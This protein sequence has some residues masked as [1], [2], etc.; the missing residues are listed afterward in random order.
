MA[1]WFRNAALS[2][3]VLAAFASIASAT[4]ITL[5]TPIGATTSGGAVDA[6]AEFITGAG[7]LTI[8]LD[9]LFADPKSIAQL[10][11]GIDFTL[12]DL[13]TTGSLTSSSGQQ[14][15]VASNGSY[16]TGATTSTGWGVDN[17][18]LGGIELTALGFSSPAQLIIGA[19]GAGNTYNNANSS[20]T[21]G[22]HDP[23]L[24]QTATFT[25]AIAGL[26]ASDKVT[27][28]TFLFGTT[29]GVD[30]VSAPEPSSLEMLGMGLI[31][32][33]GLGAFRRSSA[34]QASA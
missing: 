26:T 5:T 25:L 4:D 16:T 15:T 19:P 23:F 11:S 7:T 33:V 21:N 17:N 24:N 18:V 1:A 12:S 13:A 2:A 30:Q 3:L 27:G 34:G 32:L 6:S 22:V 31:G 10:L 14:L 29:P 20:I 8:I 9:N 28:A